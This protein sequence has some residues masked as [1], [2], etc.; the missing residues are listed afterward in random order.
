MTPKCVADERSQ[1]EV[2]SDRMFELEKR[3]RAILTRGDDISRTNDGLQM[4]I[5]NKA[6]VPEKQPVN[7]ANWLTKILNAERE[8]HRNFFGREFDLAEFEKTLR[9]YGR[10]KIKVWQNFGLEPHFLPK[11]S[12]MTGDDYPGWKV[13]PEEWFYKKQV[14]GKLFLDSGGCLEKVLTVELKGVTV[15]IDS[16]LKPAYRD[17]KQ[18]WEGDNLF[19]LLIADLR[20]EGKIAKY[21]YGPQ[22][23]RFGVSSD[24]WQGHVRPALAN[25]LGLDL[26]QLRLE[27]AIEGNVIPQL[28]P[29]MP[30]KDDGKTN[31]WVWYEEYFEGRDYRLDGG[32]FGLGGLARVSD[33]TV[34]HHWRY[35]SFRSLEVL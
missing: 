29:H 10:K 14:E 33:G 3:T 6:L 20:K 25:R 22:S 21:E 23:S 24:E 16:R 15:L 17:G 28:Y 12:M 34:G 18:M 35:R 7:R 1:K 30:R 27:Y 9:K 4:L 19:G 8:H 32:N 11:V 13:R 31:T 5:E 26:Q 2:F